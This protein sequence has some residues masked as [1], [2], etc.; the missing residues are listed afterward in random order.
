[1]RHSGHGR[2]RA[3]GDR[4]GCGG[5]GTGASLLCRWSGGELRLVTQAARHG[6]RWLSPAVRAFVEVT[7]EVLIPYKAT[8][9]VRGAA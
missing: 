3:A 1:M 8:R 4:R 7:R 9:P 2:R 5:W 6:D